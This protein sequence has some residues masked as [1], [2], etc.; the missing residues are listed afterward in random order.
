MQEYTINQPNLSKICG[1]ACV[2]MMCDY[3]SIA[4]MYKKFNSTYPNR[5]SL[6]LSEQAKIK[7]P[8][9]CQLAQIL[10]FVSIHDM[11]IGCYAVAEDAINGGRMTLK[12]SES[13]G[14][15]ITMDCPALVGVDS[16]TYEDKLHWVL[17]TGESI[18]DPNPKK[19]DVRSLSD[20]NG[21]IYDWYPII[22]FQ[23]LEC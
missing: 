7:E 14:L 2:A 20:F 4:E 3:T 13:I 21:H 17:W 10:E 11:M 9:F 5:K 15:T 16:E 19:P 6:C 12:K 23:D 22:Q 18:R 8:Y 1:A